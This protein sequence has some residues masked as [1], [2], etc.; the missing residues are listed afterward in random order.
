M[1]LLS[2]KEYKSAIW[3]INCDGYYIYCTN[4]WYEPRDILIDDLPNKCPKCGCSMINYY[5]N[6]HKKRNLRGECVDGRYSANNNKDN[7]KPSNN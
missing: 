6:L 3:E 4:C 5:K 2:D 1:K 7:I